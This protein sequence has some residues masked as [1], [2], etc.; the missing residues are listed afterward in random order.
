MSQDLEH[1]LH[2]YA[3]SLVDGHLQREYD[4]QLSK[5]KI[6]INRVGGAYGQAF[7]RHEGTLQAAKAKQKAES[8]MVMLAFSFVGGIALSW[9]SGVI[10]FQLVPRFLK[11]TPRYVVARG[12]FFTDGFTDPKPSQ[13]VAG[14]IFGE[15]PKSLKNLGAD[16]AIDIKARDEA[17][18]T[19]LSGLGMSPSPELFQMNLENAMEEEKQKTIRS[20]GS[21]ALGILQKQDYGRSC[22]ARLYRLNPRAKKAKPDEQERMGKEMIVAD[23][24]RQRKEWAP[25]WLYYGYNPFAESFE[26]MSDKIEKEIWANWIIAQDFGSPRPGDWGADGIQFSNVAPRLV[27][28]DII[29]AWTSKQMV[30]QIG[31]LTE[32]SKTV[33]VAEVEGQVDTDEELWAV[34]S[35]ARNHQ[36]DPLGGN[37]GGVS[38]VMGSIL[39]VYDSP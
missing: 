12:P 33:G 21:L 22:L 20:I 28:L 25:Q 18:G 3:H 19:A 7:K 29:P 11:M 39:D 34:D 16:V 36:P 31:R 10:Q 37:A 26:K 35:W 14:K 17:S 24:D 23:V 27:D 32:E 15:L 13:L 2:M 5:W 9:V 4:L 6:Y 38:R 8:E 30:A 1:R